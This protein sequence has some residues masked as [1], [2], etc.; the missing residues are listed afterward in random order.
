MRLRAR[1]LW[2]GAGSVSA[3]AMLHLGAQAPVAAPRERPGVGDRRYR[4]MELGTMQRVLFW[5]TKGM[6]K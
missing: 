3:V 4:N 2:I 1:L 5:G 6:F